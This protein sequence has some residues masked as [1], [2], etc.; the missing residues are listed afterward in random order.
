[1][2]SVINPV[3]S[4]ASRLRKLH[5]ILQNLFHTA[6][7]LSKY[8]DA[9]FLLSCTRVVDPRSNQD[10]VVWPLYSAT[11][12]SILAEPAGLNDHFSTDVCPEFVVSI[13]ILGPLLTSS[14]RVL[15][16]RP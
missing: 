1:M 4:A 16:N 8:R 7:P 12:R 2:F 10:N 9:F 3:A 5:F 6:R 11:L 14:R 13:R 15:L